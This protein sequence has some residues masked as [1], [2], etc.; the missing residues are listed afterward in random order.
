MNPLETLR[1]NL[2]ETLLR[3]QTR[4]KKLT[5]QIYNSP[6]NRWKNFASRR[7]SMKRCIESVHDIRSQ[8]PLRLTRWSLFLGVLQTGMGL[9]RKTKISSKVLVLYTVRKLIKN[10]ANINQLVGSENGLLTS[11]SRLKILEIKFI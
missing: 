2:R 7:K 3:E 1:N 10:W 4:L 6:V 5:E 8:K 9:H 11:Y